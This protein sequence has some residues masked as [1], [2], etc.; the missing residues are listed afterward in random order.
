MSD[1]ARG[2]QALPLL[3][4]LDQELPRRRIFT[5]PTVVHTLTTWTHAALS[6]A[7][8]SCKRSKAKTRALS[9]L[10][11]ACFT[12]W[13]TASGYIART[14]RDGQTS[15]CQSTARSSSFMVA[16]GMRMDAARGNLQSP[17]KTTGFRSLQ[18]MFSA[19]SARSMTC[20][21]WGGRFS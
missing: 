13:D 11:G 2:H 16:F 5:K 14:C 10:S 18:R 3:W 12:P 19:M 4:S 8:A 7:A 1:R 15:F 6:N 9:S 21:Q 20:V 17:D